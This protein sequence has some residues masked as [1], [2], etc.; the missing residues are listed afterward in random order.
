[1][2][3]IVTS[4]RE[5]FQETSRRPLLFSPLP[6]C[7]EIFAFDFIVSEDLKLY[8]LE[9]NAGPDMDMFPQDML[10]QIADDVASLVIPPDLWPTKFQ[11]PEDCS[12]REVGSSWQHVW[13]M[14]SRFG[15]SVDEC[16]SNFGSLVN[17]CGLFANAL[18][19]R[20]DIAPSG[21]HAA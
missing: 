11:A 3:G 14:N 16:R 2:D 12:C 1:M 20:A 21:V 7:F 9:V 18:H 6:H 4:M 8:L 13:G 10:D 17:K 5:A 15:S 19:E